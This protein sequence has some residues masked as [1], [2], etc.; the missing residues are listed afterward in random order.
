MGTVLLQ[1]GSYRHHAASA[2]TA[3]AYDAAL[4]H[5]FHMIWARSVWLTMLINQSESRMIHLRQN[6]CAIDNEYRA[7]TNY[8]FET[9]QCDNISIYV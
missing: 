6:V 1:C 7:A 4:M 2:V 5:D 9:I 8:L 3:V